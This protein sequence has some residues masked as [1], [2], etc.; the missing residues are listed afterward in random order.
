ME[1][2]R[3]R[4]RKK[5]AKNKSK[6]KYL[7]ERKMDFLRKEKIKREEGKIK[8]RNRRVV[9]TLP[10]LLIEPCVRNASR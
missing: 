8:K 5:G 4:K 1:M 6:E 9:Q 3:K 7:N 2:S 10:S